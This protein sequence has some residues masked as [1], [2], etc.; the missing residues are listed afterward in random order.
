[1]FSPVEIRNPASSSSTLR[2]AK[3]LEKESSSN[4]KKGKKKANAGACGIE[5]VAGSLGIGV[6]TSSAPVEQDPAAE[7]GTTTSSKAAGKKKVQVMQ[8][9]DDDDDMYAIEE[10]DAEEG[11]GDEMPEENV[12]GEEQAGEGAADSNVSLPPQQKRRYSQNDKDKKEAPIH[13]SIGD[14]TTSSTAVA[15]PDITQGQ[16]QQGP[17]PAANAPIMAIDPA[18]EALQVPSNQPTPPVPGSGTGI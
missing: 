6:S 4:S 18:L 13:Q 1:M 9:D 11:G 8:D 2:S 17:L 10:D 12:D 16:H 15:Q 3:T 5:E 7:L 14:P